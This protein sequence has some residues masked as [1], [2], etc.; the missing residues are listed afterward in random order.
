MVTRLKIMCNLDIS[1][2]RKPQNDRSNLNSIHHQTLSCPLAVFLLLVGLR[3]SDAY[4]GGGWV[5]IDWQAWTHSLQQ[6][7]LEK[8]VC[9]PYGLFYVCGP[10]GSGK[11]TTLHSILKF[12][13]TP[14][15]KIWTTEDPVEI[16]KKLAAGSNQ[17]TN[18]QWLCA[19][20]T[21]LLSDGLRHHH[22]GWWVVRQKTVSM[23]VVA[24]LAGLMVFSALHTNS[25]P[26][27]IT[28]LLDIG[29]D[30]FNFA[31][32]LPGKLA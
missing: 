13:N 18:R 29:I 15:F 22:H 14:N 17:Q 6:E 19:F 24:S 21:R 25:A 7:R 26:E 2:K 11:T 16:T 1:E 20:H 32:A 31:A 8:T 30:P 4:I 28:R 12:L 27:S 9:K 3:H 23:D 10:T 5:D